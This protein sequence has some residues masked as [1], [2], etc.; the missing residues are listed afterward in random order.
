MKC[1]YVN[2]P[3]ECV[4]LMVVP[5]DLVLAP[6]YSPTSWI[7]PIAATSAACCSVVFRAAINQ[8]SSPS[9]YAMLALSACAGFQLLS[10]RDQPCHR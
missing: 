7:L 5:C 9:S 1:E 4:H 2:A 8:V 10:M 6:L 3:L